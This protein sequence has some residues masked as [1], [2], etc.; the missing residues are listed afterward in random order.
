VRAKAARIADSGLI[1]RTGWFNLALSGQGSHRA[2]AGILYLDDSKGS[3]KR[4]R[5]NI[6]R[7]TI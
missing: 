1:S 4:R 3:G 6:R 2:K 7:I 5:R